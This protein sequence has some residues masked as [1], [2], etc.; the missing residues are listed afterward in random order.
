M[1]II[2]V[3]YFSKTEIS[4]RISKITDAIDIVLSGGKSYR[5]N[6]SQ[7]D[8]QVTRESLPSLRDML[9]YWLTKYD[10]ADDDSGSIVSVEVTRHG[11]F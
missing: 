11:T 5:L 8:I 2:Y 4:N 9:D 7:G 3:G 1:F 6:D 10:E